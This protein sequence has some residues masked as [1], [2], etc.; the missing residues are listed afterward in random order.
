MTQVLKLEQPLSYVGLRLRQPLQLGLK[1]LS[2]KSGIA[3]IRFQPTALGVDK[4]FAEGGRSFANP[5]LQ[6]GDELGPSAGVRV[7]RPSSQTFIGQRRK[8]CRSE[9]LLE[10]EQLGV[11]TK[12]R[13]EAS[14][15]QARYAVPLAFVIER[16]K[17][18]HR[19]RVILVRLCEQSL[20]LTY[21]RI[22]RSPGTL[23]HA[24]SAVDGRLAKLNG[25]GLEL[26]FK[27]RPLS[28]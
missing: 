23:G 20:Q 15:V 28:P 2:A 4:R 3:Q 27:L 9:L 22:D 12:E 1:H 24:Q 5:V 8:L 10:T 11:G 14:R 18:R 13:L 21:R 6:R 26:R 25:L 19:K 7:I 16:V 17:F